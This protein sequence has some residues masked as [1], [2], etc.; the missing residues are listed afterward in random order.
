MA[1]LNKVILIGRITKDPELKTTPSG[2]SVTAFGI[3]V[4]RKT[5]KD[6]PQIADFLNI[7][8]WRTT[9]E[10]VAKYFKKGQA[11][12]IVGSIQTR[13]YED[14]QGNKRIA[15]EIVADEVQFA[16][17][18]RDGNDINVGTTASSFEGD[19]AEIANDDTLPF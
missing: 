2:V 5:V 17:P 19:F 6:K 11:I 16:E 14:K 9:A 7:V 4:N 8:A 1:E 3:A 13:S 10:F 12:L 18:K 15:F